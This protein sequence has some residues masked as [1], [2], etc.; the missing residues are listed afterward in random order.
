[1]GNFDVKE[2]KKQDD[3]CPLPDIQKDK[4]QET[5]ND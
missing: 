3:P 2:V 4:K 5:E 1:L